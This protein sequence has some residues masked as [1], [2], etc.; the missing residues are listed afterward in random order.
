VML[1]LSYRFLLDFYEP[2]AAENEQ[3]YQP[4]ETAVKQQDGGFDA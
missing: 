4:A 1:S 2:Q 3:E